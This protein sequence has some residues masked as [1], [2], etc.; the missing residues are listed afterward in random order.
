ML[1]V[2]QPEE[3]TEPYPHQSTALAPKATPQAEATE[4]LMATLDAQEAARQSFDKQ[5]WYAKN[6]MATVQTEARKF[7]ARRTMIRRLALALI[8]SMMVFV[9]IFI[10]KGIL[11]GKWDWDMLMSLMS[12]TGVLG[13]AVGSSST[14]K[15][16]ASELSA[17]EDLRAVGP[18]AESLD[19]EA[20]A[21]RAQVEEALIR[22]LPRL[23]ASDAGLLNREQ[24]VCLNKALNGR[25]E[26]LII[27]ILRAYEQ[28]GDET[29]LPCVESLANE[30]PDTLSSA[31]DSRMS[32][33][34]ITG[35]L[36]A[37]LKAAP[38]AHITAAAQSCLSYLRV[39]VEQQ[40]A[41]QTLLR[42][43]S[44]NAVAPNTLLRPAQASEAT[45]PEQLL[46]PARDT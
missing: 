43:A 12:L 10:A 1:K 17:I 29:A 3:H 14:Y 23:Q 40:R 44:A 32:E 15:T 38:S 35:L 37:K 31:Q 25:N 20:T 41:S 45:H 18:L 13:T 33:S 36:G 8:T 2:E 24:R 21:V 11:R 19:I 16:A 6:L 34:I 46:R 26:D 5:E 28:V 7:R 22:L 39:R 42:G 4:R 9:G 27:A 30:T